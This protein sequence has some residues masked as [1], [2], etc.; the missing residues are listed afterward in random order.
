MRPL[1][2]KPSSVDMHPF[3]SS[4]I[5]LDS[6]Y[7]YY[8]D[9]RFLIFICREKHSIKVWSLTLKKCFIKFLFLFLFHFYH[10]SGFFLSPKWRSEERTGI[11]TCEL[12]IVTVTHYWTLH[13]FQWLWY[14]MSVFV[15]LKFRKV[16]FILAALPILIGLIQNVKLLWYI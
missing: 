7:F 2:W 8:I 16:C 4:K 1:C 5:I 15:K 3:L 11:V 6:L 14:K 12:S 9:I 13:C 10:L